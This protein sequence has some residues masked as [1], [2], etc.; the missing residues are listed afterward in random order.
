MKLQSLICLF[1][2]ENPPQQ[3][4]FNA[5]LFISNADSEVQMMTHKLNINF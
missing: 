3:Q 2:G 5:M 4:L 1:T